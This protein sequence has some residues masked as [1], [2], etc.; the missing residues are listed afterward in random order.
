[1]TSPIP[2]AILATLE[3]AHP[4]WHPALLAGLTAV[5]EANPGYLPELAGDSY[6]PTDGRL[7][8]AFAQPLN[9][10]RYVLVGEGPYPRAASA[11]GVCFM[12]GAVT[13]LWSDTGLSK[14]V[15][16]ATSLRNF[17]KMLLVAEGALHIDQTTGTAM[18][19]IGLQ[20][21]CP[22]SG[23]IQTMPQLQ[24]N[25]TAHG[26]LLLNATPVFRPDVPPVKEARFW[27][28]FLK[29]ILDSLAERSVPAP[30]LVLWGKIAAQVNA[31]PGAER[32]P[33]QAAEHPYN[34]TFIG[35]LSMHRLFGPMHLLAAPG[36]TMAVASSDS[37]KPL[38]SIPDEISQLCNT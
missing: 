8:A 17:M 35:N 27:L 15:N 6:L 12:D 4:S 13:S 20:A 10:V 30:S 31:L 36:V 16:R 38:Q 23:R 24:S 14:S 1:M 33:Q 19:A 18:A 22:D 7:L 37:R 2:A 3:Q 5:A 9:A 28:P 26:F 29:K 21:Q 32:F 25:L 34:L 11:T